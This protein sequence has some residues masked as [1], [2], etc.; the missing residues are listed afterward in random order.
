MQVSQIKNLYFWQAQNG[1]DVE[2]FFTD[3]TSIVGEDE[4]HAS[5]I[6]NAFMDCMNYDDG[7][8][9]DTVIEIKKTVRS[10]TL[11]ARYDYDVAKWM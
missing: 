1:L 5:A 6:V 2:I 7:Q 10:G 3:G 11:S 9:Y 8:A 4:D